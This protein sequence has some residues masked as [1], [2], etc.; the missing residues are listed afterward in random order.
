MIR[1]ARR[2]AAPDRFKTTLDS[3]AYRPDRISAAKVE[4]AGRE[5]YG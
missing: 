3:A 4:A 2:L 5:E 1:A